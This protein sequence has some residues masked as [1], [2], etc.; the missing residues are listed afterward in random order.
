MA[1]VE[2]PCA[3][4]KIKQSRKGKNIPAA[5]RSIACPKDRPAFD[6]ANTEPNAPPAPMITRIPPAFSTDSC[7]KAP[8]LFLF[9]PLLQLKASNTPIAKAMTG[10]P[11][12]KKI[13]TQ[14]FG[15]LVPS[16]KKDFNA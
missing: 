13:F 9:H 2:E 6:A 1:T 7:N 10:S 5:P 11:R 16:V 12:D 3:V 15:N 8:T 4:F 14:L